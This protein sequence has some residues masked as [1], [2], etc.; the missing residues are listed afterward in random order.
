MRLE[1]KKEGFW[2]RAR[3]LHSLIEL[4][5]R[6]GHAQNAMREA[7]IEQIRAGAFQTVD[8]QLA[9]SLKKQGLSGLEEVVR[10]TRPG[11]QLQ[12]SAAEFKKLTAGR[13]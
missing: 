1:N 10:T 9:S 3:E 5:V 2:A 4:K 8:P 7:L 11:Q 6:Q 12:M 13:N